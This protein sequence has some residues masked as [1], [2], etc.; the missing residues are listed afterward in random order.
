M[1]EKIK[2]LF[3]NHT[4]KRWHFKSLLEESGISRERLGYFLAELIK[5]KFVIRVKK[6]W[7]MPYYISN[8]DSV[9]FRIEKKLF[10]LRLLEESGLFEGLHSCKNIKTAIL[11]GSFARGD[12][13]KSSD[14]DLFIYGDDAEFEK[15]IYERKLQREIQLFSYSN[16]SVLKKNLD[17]KVLSNIVKGFF[18]TE[19]IDPFEVGISA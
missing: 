18:I 17:S 7:K 6:K 16:K 5:E 10:G 11:F 2:A 3:F 13:S 12:W 8:R 15:N 1:K 19:S 14:I 9:K 4:L